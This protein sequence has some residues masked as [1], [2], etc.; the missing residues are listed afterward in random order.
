MQSNAPGY[1]FDPTLNGFDND[2]DSGLGPEEDTADTAGMGAWVNQSPV[3]GVF[4]AHMPSYCQTGN[5]EMLTADQRFNCGLRPTLSAGEQ[6]Q[7]V[8]DWQQAQASAQAAA[9]AAQAAGI[10]AAAGGPDTVTGFFPN[11]GGVSYK[12]WIL[13]AIALGIGC[14]GLYK[15]YHKYNLGRFLEPDHEPEERGVATHNPPRRRRRSLFGRGRRQVARQAPS[16]K[17]SR[18]VSMRA[19]CSTRGCRRLAKFDGLCRG[20]VKEPQSNPNVSRIGEPN[21]SADSGYD[22]DDLSEI[23]EVE[24]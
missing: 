1:V 8:Q 10:D 4:T 24:D 20:C 6:Q 13:I 12:K 23:V 19:K 16:R 17:S 21:D 18:K 11:S 15:L 5:P 7:S 2:E 14:W 3:A 22:D 9:Q